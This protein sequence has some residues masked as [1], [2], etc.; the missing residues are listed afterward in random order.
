MIR[1]VHDP[2]HIR[3]LKQRRR[4]R[5]QE[6]Q[7]SNWFRLANNSFVRVSRFFVHFFAVTALL[8]RENAYFHV[9]WR[10]W[11]QDHDFLFLLLNFDTIFKNWSPDKNYQ[12]L[13]NWTRWN[14]RDKVKSS[15]TSLL[16]WRFRSRRRPCCLSSLLPHLSG[17][18]HLH[19]NRPLVSVAGH[20]AEKPKEESERNAWPDFWFTVS[21]SLPAISMWSLRTNWIVMQAVCS[22]R[23]ALFFWK[24]F[25]GIL[26]MADSVSFLKTGDHFC[27]KQRKR[28]EIYGYIYKPWGGL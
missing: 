10:T 19:V 26:S 9:L 20:N 3:E 23:S 11:T 6:R 13:T 4:R 27:M 24:L 17:V 21:T 15:A 14:K 12:H 2:P 28:W 22:E 1:G 16:E 5:Q 8:R 7:K 25:I 18:P